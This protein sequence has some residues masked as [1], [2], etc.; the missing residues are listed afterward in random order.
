[1]QL[2]V[3]ADIVTYVWALTLLH[4]L[5]EHV[6]RGMQLAM[7][8]QTASAASFLKPILLLSLCWCH[9]SCAAVADAAAAAVQ[10]PPEQGSL[11]YAPV[12]LLWQ[13]A[14][15]NLQNPLSKDY[16]LLS[17][18]CCWLLLLLLCRT[19]TLRTP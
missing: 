10:E 7:P 6:P 14:G 8:T 17:L 19:P 5:A 11:A 16:M 15:P 9:S 2:C 12:L 13:L 4:L 1:M 18:C 3:G